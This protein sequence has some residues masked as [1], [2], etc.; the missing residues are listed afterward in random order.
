MANCTVI[1]DITALNKFRGYFEKVLLGLTDV[2]VADHLIDLKAPVAA[3]WLSGKRNI[4]N[5]EA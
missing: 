5:H 4:C 1:H 2:V 3:A